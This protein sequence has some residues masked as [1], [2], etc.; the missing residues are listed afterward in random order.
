MIASEYFNKLSFAGTTLVLLVFIFSIISASAQSLSGNIVDHNGKPVPYSTVF[1]KE[2]MYGTA[3]NQEGFFE[4]KLPQG[5]YSCVFQSMGYETETLK[6]SVTQSMKPLQIVLQEMVYNLPGVVVSSDGEDPAYGIIRRVIQKAPVYARIVKYY[7]ADVYI[8][9]SLEVRSISRM[10]KWMAKDDLKESGIKEG[11][12]Y[13][14]ESVNE[15]EYT[16][17]KVNQRVKSIRS[18]FPQG[19]ESRSS[20]AIGYISGNLYKPDAFGNAWSPFAP[21]AFNHYR[22][23]LEGTQLNGNVLVNKIRITPKGSGPKYVKG[24]VYIVDELWCIH[25]ID[26]S[27]DEQLGMKIQLAQTYGEVQPNVWL[28]VSNKFKF[29]MDLMGNAGGFLYNTSIRYHKLTVN[30]QDVPSVTPLPV[31]LMAKKSQSSNAKRVEKLDKKSEILKSKQEPTTTEAYRLARIQSRQEELKLKDSL[32]NNHEYVERYKTNIDSNARISDTG[33]WNNVRPIPLAHHEI[34]SVERND[35]LMARRKSLANDT[36]GKKPA[37]KRLFSTLLTGGRYDVD[38]VR[39]LTSNGL[40]YPF[41]LAFN[42][43]DGLA[44]RTMFGYNYRLS[45]KGV[46]NLAFTPGVSFARE[47]FL[48]NVSA[49]FSGNG[50]YKNSI[51]F[52]A[53]SDSF[54]YNTAGGAMPIENT[55]STLFF[56]QNLSRIYRKDYVSLSHSIVPFIGAKVKSDIIVSESVPLQNACD[57]SFFYK[58]SR[59]FDSNIPENSLYSMQRHRDLRVNLE[60]SWKPTPYYFVKDGVKVARRGLN[61]A[62][63]FFVGFNKAFKVGAFDTNFDLL[64]TGLRQEFRLGIEGSLRYEAEFGKYL[65]NNK[66]Y[67]DDFTHFNSQPLILGGKDFF[68][69]FHLTDYYKWSTD[70]AYVNAHI[71]YNSKY[72]FLNRLPLLRNRLWEERF[73]L[74]FLAVQ[75][76]GHHI[77]AGYGIGNALYNLGIY[78]GYGSDE[79]FLWGIRIAIPVFSRREITIGM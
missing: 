28:A 45:E 27:I 29:D 11:D 78:A 13:I 8:R 68:Q 36:T 63:E 23:S 51:R 48:W 6:V 59:D 32:R 30:M 22:F 15:I 56:R 17:S 52:K 76:K 73:S 74:S 5:D 16:P 57:F 39:W 60:L 46:F 2:L 24:Y 20:S 42:T 77:E 33:F 43:V 49:G 71:I 79:K 72:L 18:N 21:G 62:P 9:G 34:L 75:H 26:V 7:K 44:Y 53:G 14:E 70:E 61:K 3:A 25:S 4:L 65:N 69:V 40:L 31:E 1:I 67:F 38:S 19:N 41:G 37:N 50:N 54:D 66:L 55:I 64:R 47:A 58:D 12:V 35:S 10:V